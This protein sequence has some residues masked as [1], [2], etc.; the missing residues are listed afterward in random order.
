MST[1]VSHS[2][3]EAVSELVTHWLHRVSKTTRDFPEAFAGLA[4]EKCVSDALLAAKNA[5]Q[6]LCI[7]EIFGVGV[8]FG[9]AAAVAALDNPLSVDT[10]RLLA[11]IRV[12]DKQ[13]RDLAE[14]A[15]DDMARVA[16]KK[17]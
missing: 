15:R 4:A 12:A 6:E 5:R 9:I 7:E 14:S 1:A 16:G 10:D 11:A 8:E 13:I 17:S 2:D 3:S